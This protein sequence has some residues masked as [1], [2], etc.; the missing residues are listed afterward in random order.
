MPSDVGKKQADPSSCVPQVTQT[1]YR[2]GVPCRD[3]IFAGQ[4]AITKF[5]G[6]GDNVYSCFY[7]LASAFDTVEFCILLEQLFHAC[8]KGKCWRL[9]WQWYCNPTSQVKLGNLLSKPFAIS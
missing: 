9:M 2:K 6:E 7:D 4:E 5:T 3:A 8:V 1:A